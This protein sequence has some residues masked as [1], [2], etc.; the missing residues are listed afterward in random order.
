MAVAGDVGLGRT[1]SVVVAV[2][3][4][5]RSSGVAVSI[6]GT[7]VEEG[8]VER[9]VW[10][11]LRMALADTAAGNGESGGFIVARRGFGAVYE[12]PSFSILEVSELSILMATGASTIEV[13]SVPWEEIL[14]EEKSLPDSSDTEEDGRDFINNSGL[15]STL[16][17]IWSINRILF[18]F[19]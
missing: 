2:D 13:A 19:C 14:E 12:T 10:K 1:V 15:E 5:L 17:V 9:V 8:W 3:S 6:E 7:I 11:V 18:F 16:D 4:M